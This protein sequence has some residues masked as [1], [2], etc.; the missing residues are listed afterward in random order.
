MIP[1]I[2]IINYYED[3]TSFPLTAKRDSIRNTWRES[4]DC[5]LHDHTNMDPWMQN[6]QNVIK[7]W[8]QH[9]HG[10]TQSQLLNTGASSMSSV[11][12]NTVYG[13]SDSLQPDVGAP[14]RKKKKRK[15]NRRNR[16]EDYSEASNRLF[17]FLSIWKEGDDTLV[18]DRGWTGAHKK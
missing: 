16:A 2:D 6:M 18:Q 3:S 14:W 5:G 1:M 8:E 15:T 13:S 4:S 11:V 9:G 7:K 10:P 12:D 17:N